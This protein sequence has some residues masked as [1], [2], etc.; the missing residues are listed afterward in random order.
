MIE[1]CSAGRDGDRRGARPLAAFAI[2][3]LCHTLALLA[4]RG[5]RV[6]SRPAL[7][8][9]VTMV[10]RGSGGGDE[11]GAGASASTPA[12]QPVPA[13]PGLAAPDV[14]KVA[15]PREAQR[16]HAPARRVAVAM[17]PAIAAR[18][19]TTSAL[20][21][22][23]SAAGA[24]S[25]GAPGKLPAGGAGSGM[26]G[27][28]DGGAPGGSGGGAGRGSDGLRA[29]CRRCPTPDYPNRARRQGWQ[30]TVDIEL[31]IGGD[32]AV[33]VARLGR[34]SGYPTLDEVA[35]GVARES[36]FTVPSGGD[37]LRGQ[38]RYRFVL[39]ETAAR[40]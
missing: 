12:A 24:A 9:V 16:Q 7:P 17:Q 4:A 5:W 26:G 32:G 14:K 3:L 15:P 29:F 1:S 27:V 23:K 40:R 25:V 38:L 36:R 6:E 10:A 11:G 34:S 28:G 37:G 39:D 19:T 35:L 21:P 8:L 31:T 33:Q 20:A 13:V 30:G 22:A 18:T 2:S